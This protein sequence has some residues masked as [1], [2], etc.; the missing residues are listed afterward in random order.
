MEIEL[1]KYR[2]GISRRELPGSAAALVMTSAAR[3]SGTRMPFGAKVGRDVLIRAFFH[4]RRLT[5]VRQ[6]S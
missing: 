1:N 6:V 5:L 2:T 4:P 3:R